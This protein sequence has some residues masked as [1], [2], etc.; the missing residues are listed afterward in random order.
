[1]STEDTKTIEALNR[2]VEHELAGT[3]RYTQYSLMIFGHARIPI[4]SW[5]QAQAIEAI[6]HARMAGEEV[7]NLGG[8]VSLG[9]G[10]LVGS[11]HD[12]VDEIMAELVLHE[13]AGIEMYRELLGLVANRNVSLE[14]FAR[15]QIRAEELHVS[16]IKKMLRRRGD[17]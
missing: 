8:Q 5:M 3:V 14:E 11:H 7:T 2:I 4:I 9:I 1:M 6:D 13:E 10:E 12:G 15:Q 16:E 17:A